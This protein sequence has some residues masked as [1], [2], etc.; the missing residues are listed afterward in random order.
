MEASE[1]VTVRLA[2]DVHASVMVMPNPSNAATVVTAA[3]AS[4]ATHPSTVAVAIVPVIEGA[5][6]SFTLMTCVRVVLLPHASVTTYV[7]V[8]TI[9]QVPVD[10]SELVTTRLASEVQASLIVNPNPSSAET[11]VTAAATA[12]AAQPS[13]VVVAIDP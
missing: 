6:V 12:F 4:P 10:A 2:S 7:L 11:V 3:V 13:M 8:T 5:V 1:L 9:G